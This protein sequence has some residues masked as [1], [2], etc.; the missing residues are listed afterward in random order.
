M[1]FLPG[2]L[3][4]GT[5]KTPIG[6]IKLPDEKRKKVEDQS[7]KS[8]GVVV[9]IRPEDFEDAELVG[10]NRD[11]GHVI[12]AEIDVLESLGSDKFAYFTVQGERAVAKQL[13]EI[14]RDA[15][16]EDRTSGDGIQVTARLDAA[17]KA[18]EDSKLDIWIDVSKIHVFDPDTGKNLTL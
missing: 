13:E 2:N 4:S 11:Q 10:D 9:G 15:G 12:S 14:A 1:N 5:I 16:A 18:A 3:E 6:D 7:G 8:Q 17:S